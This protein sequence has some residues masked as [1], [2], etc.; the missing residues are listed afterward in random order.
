MDRLEMVYRADGD[1]V[2][3]GALIWSVA[4]MPLVRT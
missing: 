3:E 2:N 4:T 1:Q